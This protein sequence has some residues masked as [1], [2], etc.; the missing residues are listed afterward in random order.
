MLIIV[1]AIGCSKP[2]EKLEPI[3]ALKAFE[4]SYKNLSEK[5]Q[6]EVVQILAKSVLDSLNNEITNK[7][8]RNKIIEA[9]AQNLKNKIYLSNKKPLD[10]Y[11]IIKEGSHLQ[12]NIF[13]IYYLAGK[14]NDKYLN[15]KEY[16]ES[17]LS[18]LNY[19]NFHEIVMDKIKSMS[20]KKSIN[21][22]TFKISVTQ[23]DILTIKNI[24]KNQKNDKIYIQNK[25]WI[26]AD[27]PSK[28]IALKIMLNNNRINNKELAKNFLE[29]S[30][31]DEQ[32]K[33]LEKEVKLE[34]FFE[35]KLEVLRAF[36]ELMEPLI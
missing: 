31:T 1:L 14:I 4:N 25:G 24:L 30:H 7:L 10:I 35:K 33:A 19:L 28:I 23:K 34:Y 15:F 2:M 11:Y 26:E 12:N 17:L 27:Y 13:N 8:N 6:Q 5:Q 3:D 9:L 20:S 21:E 18:Y 16:K 36:K 22:V 29:M 32:L